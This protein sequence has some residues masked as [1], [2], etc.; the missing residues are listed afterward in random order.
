MLGLLLVVTMLANYLAT[1]LPAEMRVNDANHALSVENQVSRLAAALRGAAEVGA[2]GAV[3]SQPVSLG[4]V[5]DPPFAA[6]D[7]SSIGTGVQGSQLSVSFTVTGGS[8][9]APPSVG[10]AG[11]T[12]KGASCTTSSTSL[13]CSTSGNKVIW[14]FTSSTPTSISIST[15]GGPYAINTSA[16]NSSISITASSAAP[17]YLLL[18]GSNDTIT[19]TVSGSSTVVH[20]VIVGSYDTVNFASGS[21]SSSTVTILAVGNHDSVSTGAMSASSSRMVATFFGS[22]DSVSL[23]TTS[24]TSSYFNVY[25][26]GF[27]PASPSSSCPVDNLAASTDTVS[28]PSSYSGSGTYNVTYNDTSVTSG[29]TSAP[30]AGTFGTPSISCPFYSVVSVPQHSSGS[31]GASF[32]VELKNTYTPIQLVAFDQGAVVY[33]QPNGH[34]LMLVGP[35]IS[36]TGGDLSLWVPEFLGGVGTQVGIG[37]AELSARL[38]SLLNVSLPSAGF[39]LTGVTSIA[40]TTPYAAAWYSYLSA[41]TSSLAGDVVCIPK[42]SSACVGP[43]TLNGPVGHVY[44]NVTASELAVQFATYSVILG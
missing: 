19:F 11:G 31:V 21:W 15:S 34:P 35:S 4:S 43:F 40:V 44:L 42:A 37:I 7:G 17:V 25:F 1:Q 29:S 33:A 3:L 16:S 23:G 9:Y 28:G 10:P 5:G 6:P 12:T 14:N 24:A 20:L 39:S 22:N 38:V 8:T 36:Y 30:W 26:N 27:R 41:P 32:V 13:T 2:V 18:V